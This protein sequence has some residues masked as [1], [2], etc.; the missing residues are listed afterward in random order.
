M[1]RISQQHSTANSVTEWQH[2]F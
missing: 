2:W 1:Q